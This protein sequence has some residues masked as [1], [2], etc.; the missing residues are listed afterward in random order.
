MKTIP[1]SIRIALPVAYLLL[2]IAAC[3]GSPAT[4]TPADS[5]IPAQAQPE[6]SNP[7]YLPMT[8]KDGQQQPGLLLKGHVR[9][10]DGTPLPGVNIYR[11]FASYPAVLIA[12]S[13][14]DGFFLSEFAPI[15]GDEMVTVYAELAGYTF[16]PPQVY[17]R[18]YH[19][20]EEKT[21]DFTATLAP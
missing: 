18:H 2:S 20:Y 13:D 10:P 16:E 17:W 9:F 15:P 8:V 21:Q 7:V 4:L 19:S 11:S 12:T 1:H 14:A 5:S 3:A 6:L